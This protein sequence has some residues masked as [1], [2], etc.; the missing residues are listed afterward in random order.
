MFIATEALA[1]AEIG[2]LRSSIC[3]GT[4]SPHGEVFLSLRRP[5]VVVVVAVWLGERQDVRVAARPV[6]C[7]E[8][9]KG[10]IR[11]VAVRS[12]EGYCHFSCGLFDGRALVLQCFF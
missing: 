5:C 7:H 10:E 6:V 12:E 4:V 8:A 3:L 11:I 1:W 2:E 9:H